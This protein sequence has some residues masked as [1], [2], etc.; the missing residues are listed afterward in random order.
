M[1]CCPS[2]SIILGGWEAWRLS[3]ALRAPRVSRAQQDGRPRQLADPTAQGSEGS[4]GQPADLQQAQTLPQKQ[5]VF[6][7]KTDSHPHLQSAT[8]RQSREK[9]GEETR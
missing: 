7:S 5:Q 6:V 3:D 2:L 1:F 9:T 4:S 8:M